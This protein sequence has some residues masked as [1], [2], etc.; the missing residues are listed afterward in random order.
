[1]TWTVENE[2]AV[3]DHYEV[4]RSV[5]GRVFTSIQTVLPKNNGRTSNTYSTFDYNISSLINTGRIYYKIKQ[6]DRDGKFAY[7]ETRAIVPDVKGF[8]VSVYPNPVAKSCK[9]NINLAEAG[10]INMTIADAS[11][12]LIKRAAIDGT[13]GSNEYSLDM[14]GLA[15]GTYFI[16]ADCGSQHK[17]ISVVKD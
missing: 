1:M 15:K 6:V 16:K 8:E 11:G 17:T 14:T 4:E 10:N 3:T 5:D 12:K 9:I 2:S 7:T 13:I